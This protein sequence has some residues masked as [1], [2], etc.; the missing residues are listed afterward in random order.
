MQL[1]AAGRGRKTAEPPHGGDVST[2]RR[3]KK[4]PAGSKVFPFP[5]ALTTAEVR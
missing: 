2:T 4:K 3:K 1:A 5:R